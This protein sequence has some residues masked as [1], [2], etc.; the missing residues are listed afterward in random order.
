MDPGPYFISPEAGNHD[1]EKSAL[2]LDPKKSDLLHRQGAL[3]PAAS[4]TIFTSSA[5]ARRR[6]MSSSSAFL[7]TTL[8]FGEA[9]L[10][11]AWEWRFPGNRRRNQRKKDCKKTKIRRRARSESTALRRL[12]NTGIIRPL[13]PEVSSSMG[14]DSMAMEEREERLP[15]LS[16][17][18]GEL[19]I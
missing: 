16:G 19:E 9:A 1:R 14:T 4:G 15:V 13:A 6:E 2:L 7:K 12:R 10:A 5:S 18:G 8:H 17:N 3:P 11:G